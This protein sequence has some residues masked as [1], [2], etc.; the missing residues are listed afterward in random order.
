MHGT[1]RQTA[2]GGG[3]VGR[4]G[5]GPILAP[6]GEPRAA[7]RS[8]A[9]RRRAT[10]SSISTAPPGAGRPRRW[11]IGVWRPASP[12]TS[13]SSAAGAVDHGRLLVEVGGAG[14]E[15]E[16]RSGTRSMRSSDPSSARSTDRAL[17]AHH[18]AA[19]RALLDDHVVAE[20]AG[21]DE[22][23]VVVTG[24]L[25]RGAGHPV[26]HDHRVERVVGRVRAGQLDAEV[27]QPGLRRD[28]GLHRGDATRPRRRP[29]LPRQPGTGDEGDPVGPGVGQG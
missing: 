20:R 5:H 9:G 28:G 4:V 19:S 6:I 18:R 11:P 29:P 10:A 14:H 24:Q 25:A 1:R 13:T 8:A 15:P 7:R 12:N 2:R 27:P 21:V 17:S 3:A 23:P 26:V 22:L 16:Q